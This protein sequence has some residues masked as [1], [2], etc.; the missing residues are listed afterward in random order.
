[1]LKGRRAWREG[2]FQGLLREKES[3]DGTGDRE[4]VLLDKQLWEGTGSGSWVSS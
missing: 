2:D 3:S 4:A 1:M